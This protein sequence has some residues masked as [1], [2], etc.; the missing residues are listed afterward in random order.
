MMIIAFIDKELKN[1]V[2][3]IQIYV[4]LIIRIIRDLKIEVFRHF[5]L[6]AN[7]K[8]SRDQGLS[9]RF[10]VWGWRLYRLD[11]TPEVSYLPQGFLD[12]RTS[13]SHV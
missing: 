10:E 9:V 4:L 1:V 8:K 3:K 12:P 2:Y 11:H 7:V 6:S 13:Q 5:P